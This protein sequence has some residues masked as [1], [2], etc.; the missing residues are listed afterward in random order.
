MSNSLEVFKSRVLATPIVRLPLFL[1][2]VLAACS[3]QTITSDRIEV[4]LSQS[5]VKSI[6]GE[7]SKVQEFAMPEGPFF[8]PQ[9]VLLELA[10]PGR[11]ILEWVYEQGEAVLYIWFSGDPGRPTTSFRVIEFATFPNDAVF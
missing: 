11:A 8:G 10:E 2:I 5:D 4:G 1:L 3:Q 6:L 7:P 9:E